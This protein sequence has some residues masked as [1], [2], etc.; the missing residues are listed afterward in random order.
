MAPPTVSHWSVKTSAVVPWPGVQPP[1]HAM[2]LLPPT[3]LGTLCQER[4]Q[5]AICENARSCPSS[6]LEKVPS[7]PLVAIYAI[8]PPLQLC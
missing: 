1:S 6:M 4:S 8:F 5:F 2:Q 3:T 7:T